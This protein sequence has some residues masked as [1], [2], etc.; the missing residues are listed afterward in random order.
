MRFIVNTEE[1]RRR[2]LRAIGI[3]SVD[4]LF[5]D[6]PSQV[7][8]RFT[9]LGLEP[10]SEIEVDRTLGDLAARNADAQSHVSFQ[11]GGVYDHHVPAVVRHLTARSE[12]A[13]AYT[14]YQPEI[15]QGTLTAMFEFQTMICE[16][17]GMDVAN[18]S[19]YDG[20]SA[21]AEAALLAARVRGRR[22]LLVSEGLF[23]HWQRVLETY[24]WASG[25]QIES[26][27]L[28]ESGRL[29]RSFVHDEGDGLVVQSPNAWG[30]LESFEDLK[31]RLGDALLIAACHPLALALIE[32][33]GAFGA[34]IVVAEGQPLGLPMAYGGPLL[35]LFATRS[36]L[37]RQLPGRIASR[38]VDPEGRVGYTLAAQTREQHIRRE[39]ATSNICTNAAL[40]A[41]TATVFLA[42]HGAEGLRALAELNYRKAHH[43]A[44]A[45]GEGTAFATAFDA[46]F[47]NE[48]VVRVPEPRVQ[49]LRDRLRDVGILVDPLVPHEGGALLRL[50]VTERRTAAE[51]DRL[52]AALRE[53]R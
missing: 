3:D 41:L 19:L 44:R 14:P 47:F 4:A 5:D 8:D 46:P 28:D 36:A 40:C 21:V 17:T 49:G 51:I 48:F 53:E 34:D 27:P 31:S 43:A 12:F 25:I 20:A 39:R 22:R 50:A 38:T 16:L 33:P 11:G 2:M 10:C 7:I 15:S 52:V 26:V 42:L 32:P 37:L 9:P 30:I 23:P 29:D 6:I 24:A 45:L 1:D 35:G 13:T 18:A